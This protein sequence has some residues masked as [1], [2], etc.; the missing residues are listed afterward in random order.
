MGVVKQDPRS[1]F[2]T[3]LVEDELAYGMEQLGISPSTMRRRV[4]EVLDLLGLTE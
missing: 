3:D 1:S 2:V 4:E